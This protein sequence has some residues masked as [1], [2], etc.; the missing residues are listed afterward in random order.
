LLEENNMQIVRYEKNGK[1]SYGSLSKGTIKRIEGDVFKD[2]RETEETVP[3]ADVK[4]LIPCVPTNLYCVGLNFKEHIAE[5][6]LPTPEVPANF[7]KPVTGCVATGENIV[8]PR[9]A[10]RVDYEGEMAVVIKDKI[11]NVD[12]KEAAKHI[13][14]VTPLN[15]VTERIMSYTSTQVTY[16]KS[17]DTFTSFGPIID[18]GVDPANTVIRTYLNGKKMQEGKTSEFLFSPAHVVSFFSQGRTL[19]PGDVISL[20]TPNNVCG[21]KDGDVVEVEVEGLEMRLVNPVAAER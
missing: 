7:M 4:L 2:F 10:E 16:S 19:F 8:I 9:V 21:M 14:G 12:E 6:G 15:D 18:T 13:F 5:L 17:F 11:K 1:I 20:G 3:V